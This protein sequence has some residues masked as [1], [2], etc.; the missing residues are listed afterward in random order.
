[1]AVRP[2]P[3]IGCARNPSDSMRVQTARTCLTAAERDPAYTVAGNCAA[4]HLH[5]LPGGLAIFKARQRMAEL[6]RIKGELL[7]LPATGATAAAEDHFRQ[8]LDWARRQGT[9]SWELP[10]AASLARLLRD[11]GRSA[12]AVALLQPPPTLALAVDPND[13]FK[14]PSLLFGGGTPPYYHD[15]RAPTLETLISGND[16]RM[17]R[18][19]QLTEE[20]RAA[21]VAFLK[22]L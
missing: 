5:L 20:D 21:L 22:T 15:G 19:R 11:Q 3:G 9:L 8:A 1:M 6:L 2:A 17:G 16:D 12:D 18:T 10:A 14:T 13:A 4:N 7:L